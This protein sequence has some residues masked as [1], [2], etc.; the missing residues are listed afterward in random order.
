M[1]A[2]RKDKRRKLSGEGVFIAYMWLLYL[3]DV[4]PV[5]FTVRVVHIVYVVTE[6]LA[7]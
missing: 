1:R 3:R 7:G 6:S 4:L 5:H 2:V